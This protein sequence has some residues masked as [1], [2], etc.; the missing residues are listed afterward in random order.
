M[1]R[2]GGKTTV[3]RGSAYDKHDALATL[4][5]CSPL[6]PQSYRAHE[7]TVLTEKCPE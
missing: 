7:P 1:G 4:G 3:D 6:V 5:G 2:M